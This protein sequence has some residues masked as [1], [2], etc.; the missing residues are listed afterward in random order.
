[1]IKEINLS[2]PTRRNLLKAAFAAGV[3]LFSGMGYAEENSKKYDTAATDTICTPDKTCIS[4]T[5]D[6]V[7]ISNRE[8]KFITVAK[9][10]RIFFEK[11]ESKISTRIEP[12][13]ESGRKAIIFDGAKVIY[14]DAGT[15]TDVFLSV[16]GIWS[17]P[18][19]V[20]Y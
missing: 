10:G 18:V 14:D 15:R 17:N 16:N 9:N 12:A 3:V 8:H 19:T 7:V 5:L 11:L 20:E 1:M 6:L 4:M 2:K 13:A